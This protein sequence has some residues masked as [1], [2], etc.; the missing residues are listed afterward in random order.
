MK[1]EYFLYILSDII[2]KGVP[3]IVLL[4][5]GISLESNE[6]RKTEHLFILQGLLINVFTFGQLHLYSKKLSYSKINSNFTK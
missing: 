2:N 4:Y 1:K 5:L 3:L 6:I